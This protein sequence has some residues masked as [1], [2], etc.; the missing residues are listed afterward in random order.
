MSD[1]AAAVV[2]TPSIPQLRSMLSGEPPEPVEK[3][4]ETPTPET[5][6]ADKPVEAKPEPVEG[7]GDQ[8]QQPEARK[9]EDPELPEGVR[10]RIDRE[11][12]RQSLYRAKID[13]AVAETKRLEAEHKRLT[14]GGKPG[15]E[16]VKPSEPTELKR[17]VRPNLA[18]FDGTIEQYEAAVAEHEVKLD[19]YYA[20]K[21]QQTVRQEYDAEVKRRAI[22]SDF[23]SAVEQHGEAFT[24]AVPIVTAKAPEA[25]QQAISSQERWSE[26]VIELSKN[27]A[28]LDALV[29][30]FG[31]NPFA[32]V[33]ELGRIEA[34]LTAKVAETHPEPGK[35]KPEAKA[36]KEPDKPLPH[37][38]DSVGGGASASAEAPDLEKMPFGPGWKKA[39]AKMLRAS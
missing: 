18:T 33:A 12:E 34:R 1:A 2:E 23:R 35:A 16:P 9:P 25:L 30:K 6:P 11:I 3:A 21:S 4:P 20:A 28:E 31:A 13:E 38:P 10:K 29:A 7:A 5:P 14:E 24:K 27:P 15:T 26:I 22:Q 8:Q 37:P 19:E 32:A 17:P 36:P 39:A